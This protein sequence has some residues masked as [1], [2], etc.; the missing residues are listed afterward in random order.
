MAKVDLGKL[1]QG[2]K[3]FCTFLIEEELTS[4]KTKVPDFIPNTPEEAEQHKVLTAEYDKKI[5]E[6]FN[7]Y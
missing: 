1:G 5:L 7:S 2:R 3:R 4:A 6:Q